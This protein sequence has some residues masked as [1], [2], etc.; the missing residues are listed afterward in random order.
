[1]STRWMDR[2]R[3]PAKFLVLGLLYVVA[4]VAVGIGLYLHLNRVVQS[5][6]QELAGI[7]HVRR[8]TKTMQLMQSHRGLSATLFGGDTLSNAFGKNEVALLASFMSAAQGVAADTVLQDELQR[9]EA[10]WGLLR[11]GGR[12]WAVSDNFLAHNRLLQNLQ[13]MKRHIA[14]RSM[15]SVDPDIDAHYLLDT[16]ID[17]L[18]MAL[19]TIAQI[20]GLGA[21]ILAKGKISG[22]QKL[23][24]HV[25]LSDLRSARNALSVNLAD[26]VRHN[27]GVSQPLTLAFRDFDD[28]LPPLLEL[29]ETDILG[30]RFGK[31]SIDYFNLVTT[32]VDRGYQQ[33]FDALLPAADQLI[34]SRIATARVQMLVSAGIALALL[35]AA[36]L[37]FA[38]IYYSTIGSVQALSDA[39]GKFA[40]GDFSQRVQLVTRDEMAQVGDSFNRM[41]DG[42]SAM[43]GQHKDNEERLRSV[44][45]SA[46]DAVIQ[47]D[48]SG[49]ITGWSEHAQTIF[50]WSSEEA[51]RQPLHETIIPIRYRERHR[52][53]MAR[54]LSSGYLSLTHRSTAAGSRS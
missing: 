47:M 15:L 6:E 38:G 10:D 39:A 13:T 17:T 22:D 21:G 42:F 20:R 44:V 46:L 48:S 12:S 45:N 9:I 50:G 49:V 51:L 32:V 8:I 2:L 23:Q 26:V 19:E 18:P 53:G 31:S 3:L 27:P 41:A 4:V 37:L 11:K 54:F 1:M 28:A 33:L 5:S 14:D 16:S 43:L 40:A 30:E 35:L 52:M 24:M 34:R 29:V 7:E 36:C 25:L